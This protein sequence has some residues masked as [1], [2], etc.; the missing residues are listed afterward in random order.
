MKQEKCRKYSFFVYKYRIYSLEFLGMQ[1]ISN[2]WNITSR[3][4]RFD[5]RNGDG[6]FSDSA[7]F[8]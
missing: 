8:W 5:D 3:R 1:N 2:M 4:K 7:G 6:E